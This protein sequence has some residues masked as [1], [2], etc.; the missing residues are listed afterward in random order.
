MKRA[1]VSAVA[2]F[3][4]AGCATYYS[5]P[6]NS[7]VAVIDFVTDMRPVIVYRFE[8]SQCESSKQ[9]DRLAFIDPVFHPEFKHRGPVRVEAGRELVFT[10]HKSNPG[11]LGPL[12][13]GFTCNATIRFIPKAGQKY[14]AAFIR[15]SPVLFFTGPDCSVQLFKVLDDNR[16]GQ[17]LEPEE[18]AIPNEKICKSAG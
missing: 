15:T 9:G 5:A 3:S 11:G 13:G 16:G 7:P 12:L 10:M 18:T 14:Q 17:Q 6:E 2:V 8:N 4:L 1:T